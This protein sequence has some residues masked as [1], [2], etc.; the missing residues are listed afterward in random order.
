MGSCTKI[1]TPL[2]YTNAYKIWHQVYNIQLTSYLFPNLLID[3]WLYTANVG[4]QNVIYLKTGLFFPL[5]L[6]CFDDGS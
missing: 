4:A 6:L 1:H 3:V 2:F 5:R